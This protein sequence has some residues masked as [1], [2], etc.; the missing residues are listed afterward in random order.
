MTVAE[1]QLSQ[2]MEIARDKLCNTGL[3]IQLIAEQAGYL[4]AS[5]FSRAFRQRYGLGPREYR[6]VSRGELDLFLSDD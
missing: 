6:Q 3:Q 1:Y 2:K 4:N 5:D